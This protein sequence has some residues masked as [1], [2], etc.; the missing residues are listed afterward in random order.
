MNYVLIL[1]I[2]IIATAAL[3]GWKRGLISVIFGLV[4]MIAALILAT[5]FGPKLSDLIQTK[6]EVKAKLAV[7]LSETLKLDELALEFPDG[8]GFMEKLELPTVL[9]DM[10]HT[11]GLS[12]KLNLNNLAETASTKVAESISNFLAGLALAAVC[13]IIVFLVALIILN[14]LRGVLNIFSKLPLLKEANA[15]GGLVLGL[16]QGILIIWILFAVV[17]V[18]S[19]TGF[20]Q[21]V[22]DYIN[23]SELLSFLYTNN[24]PMK[25]IRDAVANVM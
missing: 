13:Y 18:F 25:F 2:L 15:L 14:C 23:D 4:S 10:L 5:I 21:A 3:I 20:G 16:V 6:T 12:E 24:I 1:V 8:E 11:E 7:K 9:T 22:L 19:G 17:T